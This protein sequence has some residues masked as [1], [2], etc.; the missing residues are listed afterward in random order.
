[1]QVPIPAVWMRGGTS[2]GLYLDTRD[3]PEDP[4]RRDQVLLAAMGSPDERQV[5]GVGGATPL[6]SK[7]RAQ[8]AAKKGR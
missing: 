7:E 5:D 3:L 2:K 8:R 1:M 4:A 6:T